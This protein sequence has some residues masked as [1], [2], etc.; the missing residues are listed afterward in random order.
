MKIGFQD[1]CE[2]TSTYIERQFSLRGTKTGMKTRD[3]CYTS[4]NIVEI[5][6][7]IMRKRLPYQETPTSHSKENDST[8]LDQRGYD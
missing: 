6:W 7:V 5:S 3:C 4:P 2:S 1:M 8:D